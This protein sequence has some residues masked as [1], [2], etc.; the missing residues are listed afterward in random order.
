M[1]VST[2]TSSLDLPLYSIRSANFKALL[3]FS[4][5]FDVSLLDNVVTALYSGS[6]G[7]EV[8]DLPSRLVYRC[9]V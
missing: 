5:E 3:D 2:S 1:E 7:K 4:R 9:C 8:G 6:G